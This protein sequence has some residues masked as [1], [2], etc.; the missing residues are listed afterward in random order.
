MRSE[1]RGAGAGDSPDGHDPATV[2]AISAVL[3]LRAGHSLGR[4]GRWE[5]V[6]ERD[7]RAVEL[8]AGRAYR[9][10]VWQVHA[11]HVPCWSTPAVGGHPACQR[12]QQGQGLSLA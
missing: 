4:M 3:F 1:A 9:S 7:T 10:P 2:T 6:A 8:F 12:V 5:A 11:Q